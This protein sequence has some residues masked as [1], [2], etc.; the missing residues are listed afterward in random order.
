LAH[1]ARKRTA[2]ALYSL[3]LVLPTLV[4]GGLHWHQLVQ[5]QEAELA[6]VPEAAESAGRRLI[7]A[8]RA[9]LDSLLARENARAFSSYQGRHL[10]ENLL[11]TGLAFVSSP[12]L[13]ENEKVEGIR[14]W[15]AWD[16]RKRLDAVPE[17]FP[18]NRWEIWETEKPELEA[19][20]ANL[21]QHDWMDGFPKRITR[22]FNVDASEVSLSNVVINL[23][24]ET[25]YECLSDNLPALEEIAHVMVDLFEYDF[26]V[27][28]YLEPDGTPRLIATRL[29][30]IDANDRL[31]GMPPCYSN[32]AEGATL[33]QGFL[34]DPEW[35]FDKMPLSLVPQVLGGDEVFHGV[36]SPPLASAAERVVERIYPVDALGFEVYDPVDATYGEMQ[37]AISTAEL[38]ARHRRQTR[39]FLAVALMLLLTLSTGMGLLLRSVHR[40]LEQAQRTENFVAAV[41]HELRTPVSAIRLYG[42]M[43]RDGWTT[44]PTKQDDYY[45]RIVGEANRL[46]TMVERVL[47]KSQLTSVEAKPQPGD[48]GELLSQLV[49]KELGPPG[50]VRLELDPKLPRVMLNRES[51]RSI[52]LNLVDNARK[53]APVRS[54]EPGAEPILVKTDASNGTPVLEVLD[55]GPGIPDEDKRKVFEAFY[56][57]GDEQTRRSKGTG[58]G[59]HLVKI[60][61][62]SMGG[63][64]VVLDRPGG[65][66]VF[67]VVFKEA[68]E[69][70]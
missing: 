2:L 13:E 52:V 58:L 51:V 16:F 47:E 5:A 23:S 43:L 41:T 49:R 46:E 70:E 50:D 28:F 21:V 30:L 68:T 56:R 64:V 4:L 42:E 27:R 12:L 57:R 33:I 20:V 24:E 17:L 29:I 10:P 9:R 32:R 25:D 19:A 54:G 66:S 31:K 67:K 65:G 7:E 8:I 26:H 34:I 37:I 14:A 40:D 38:H 62:Q 63:D 44:D 39:T 3:L 61:A 45:R 6:R 59:L 55:R 22:Y 48:L 36:G 35:F 53:Y 15:F 1:L 69:E 11:G 60:Q 18:G